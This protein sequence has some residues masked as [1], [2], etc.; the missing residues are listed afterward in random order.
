[1]GGHLLQSFLRL[2]AAGDP[3]TTHQL[4]LADIQGRDPAD[5]LFLVVGF[6]QHRVLLTGWQPPPTQVVAKWESQG[7]SR[8]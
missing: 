6:S 4:G 3:H 8:I 1:M 5:D 2:R 7:N